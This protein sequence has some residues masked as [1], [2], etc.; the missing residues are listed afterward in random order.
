MSKGHYAPGGSA[1][2]IPCAP[3]YYQV[4]CPAHRT[5]PSLPTGRAPSTACSPNLSGVQD[6]E[7]Q[8]WCNPCTVGTASN[9]VALSTNSC[10][11]CRPGTFSDAVGATMCK[12]CPA[13]QYQP[14]YGQDH[15]KDCR[16]L[17]ACTEPGEHVYWRAPCG[18][19]PGVTPTC[20]TCPAPSDAQRKPGHTGV[21]SSLAEC[22]DAL[23]CEGTGKRPVL[24]QNNQLECE[25]CPTV[26]HSSPDES[27][28]AGPCAF[29][30][31]AGFFRLDDSTCSACT[32]DAC[33]PLTGGVLRFR[34]ACRY[35]EGRA[36]EPLSIQ[37]GLVFARP[38]PA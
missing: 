26:E 17:Q 38:G 11:R 25:D 32:Q 5:L 34:E 14:D 3:G 28:S 24:T 23:Q 6:K 33:P 10:P 15:C 27:G 18:A 21:L 22:V 12:S 4:N 36:R 35:A 2:E 9:E 13:M 31:N 30:C 37:P 20:E 8:P 16:A 19:D 29:Q 1:A 7:G